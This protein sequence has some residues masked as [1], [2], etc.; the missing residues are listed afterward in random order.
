[1]KL[2]KS[3]AAIVR[4]LCTIPLT[5]VLSEVNTSLKLKTFLPISLSNT[6]LLTMIKSSHCY[7]MF[8]TFN[9]VIAKRT[10]LRPCLYNVIYKILMSDPNSRRLSDFFVPSVLLAFF[11]FIFNCLIQSCCSHARVFGRTLLHEF[12]IFYSHTEWN[13]PFLI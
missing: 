1:M 4:D 5:K 2:P 3:P 8:N 6:S 11:P 7:K 9:C 13:L 10:G 12:H